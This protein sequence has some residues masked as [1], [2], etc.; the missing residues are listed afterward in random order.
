MKLHYAAPIGG[1][2]LTQYAAAL[3]LFLFALAGLG[4]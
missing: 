3:P 2:L 1:V 4:V